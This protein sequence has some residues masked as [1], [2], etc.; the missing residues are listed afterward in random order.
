M[1]GFLSKSVGTLLTQVQTKRVNFVNLL[2]ELTR[3]VIA[4]GGANEGEMCD[5]RL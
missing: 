2:C 5:E 1:W 4:L 3:K